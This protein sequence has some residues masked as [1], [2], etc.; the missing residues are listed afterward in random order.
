VGDKSTVKVTYLGDAQSLAKASKAAQAS[1]DQV[2]K[3]V[4]AAARV[5]SFLGSAAG[6]LA[7]KGL[8]SV[9]DFALGSVDAFSAVEDATGAA[10]VQFDEALPSVLKFAD[11]A[12][13]SFGLSKRQALEAQNTFGTLGKVAGLTGGD[14]A[15]FSQKLT[16]LAGDL[17]SFKGTS[18][19]QAIGA[20]GAALRG[21]AEPIRAYGVILDDAT[22]KAQALADGLI[23][24][25][26]N[27]AKVSAA[28]V[29]VTE[30]TR[31][32]AQAIKKYGADSVEAAKADAQLGLAKNRLTDASEGSLPSLTGATKVMAAQAAIMK[33]TTDAT[34][35]YKRT[36]D[37]T[38]NTQK[39]LAAESENAQAELGQKLA[40]AV[41]FLR[42]SAIKLIGG[43]SGLG[44]ALGAV[45][46]FVEDNQGAFTAL[47]AVVGVVMLPTLVRL[48]VQYATTAAAAVA[49]AARQAAAWLIAQAGALA[50]AAVM[51]AS[52]ALMIA[53]WIAT[54]VQAMASAVRIAAA[55]LI[56]MGPI[57]LVIAAVVAVTVLIIKNWDTVKRVTI[58]VFQAVW[59]A[60]KRAFDWVKTNW[61]LLLAILTGPIGLAVLFIT[62]HWDTIV[63]TVKGLPG[64]ITKAASG[65]WDGIKDA[66]KAAINWIIQGWNKLHFTMPSVDTHIPGVG[67]VGGF[68]LGLP[69]IPQLAKGGIVKASPGG[70]LVN[71]GE[72]G[73]DE[74]VVPLGRDAGEQVIHVHVHL[75]GREVYQSQQRYKRTIGGGAYA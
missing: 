65:M 67:K 28:A 51:A 16:G 18:T 12:A 25:T 62:R 2:S 24:P 41:T 71:V 53:G 46:G 70:T 11:E 32:L 37:S 50:T 49:S 59:G 52:F 68:D 35:D 75:D 63:T 8:A 58:A 26:V 57:A 27:A 47:A 33:Q 23:K 13:K 31:A 40:P 66:F 14:L 54:G 48:A 5:G 6:N 56:A 44:A 64:R 45:T 29:N 7:A 72:G 60:I 30:K 55:W 74:A 34:G 17:A 20:V 61:P 69:Q 73:Q 43:L 3:S 22:L 19:E 9:K 15:G 1:I 38:A 4:G 39:T 36:A 42:R 10:G 21:E